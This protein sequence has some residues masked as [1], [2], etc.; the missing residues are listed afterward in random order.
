[1]DILSFDSVTAGYGLFPVVKDLSFHIRKNTV[2]LFIG[3]N[4]AGKSTI[5]KTIC[6]LTKILKGKII[7]DSYDITQIKPHE[8][9]RL[10]ISYIP[11]GRIVFSTLTVRENILMG[12][13][14]L[15]KKLREERY[16]EVLSLFPQIKP[17]LNTLASLLSGGQQQMVALARGLMI[18]PK[19]LLLDEPTLGLSP[20]MQ[21]LIFA[22]IQKIANE[23]TIILVEHN[24]KK[25][26][27]IA[28]R[29]Y[30]LKM[31]QLVAE[32][33]SHIL[34]EELLRQVYLS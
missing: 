28:D 25:A 14:T 22:E 5:I 6:G 32:G 19:L 8:I 10:G 18:K 33:D 3:P 26:S 29:V 27:L 13:F 30:L 17:F 24:V 9:V 21:K 2:N 16:E 12:G 23:S 31:G 1:M 15:P 11:Q 34:Q 4:G 20:S 7:F